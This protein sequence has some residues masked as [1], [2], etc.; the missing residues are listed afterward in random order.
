MEIKGYN[1]YLYQP[2]V[3]VTVTAKQETFCPMKQEILFCAKWGQKCK[4]LKNFQELIIQIGFSFSLDWANL[5]ILLRKISKCF[6]FIF[7]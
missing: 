6:I 7:F 5:N 4:N 1:H 3:I 2:I